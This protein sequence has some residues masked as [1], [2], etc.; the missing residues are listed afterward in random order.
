MIEDGATIQ[1]SVITEAHVGK[2]TQVGPY[3]YLRPGSNIGAGCRIGDFVE[4]KNSNIDDGAKAVS[5]THLCSNR[6]KEKPQ[7]PQGLMRQENRLKLRADPDSLAVAGDGDG[8]I[9]IRA[10]NLAAYVGKLV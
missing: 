7:Q 6:G 1:N 9:L 5:Y 3:A 8:A 2:G 10:V 4:V